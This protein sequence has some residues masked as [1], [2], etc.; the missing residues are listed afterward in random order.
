MGGD[1][2]ARQPPLSVRQP[3]PLVRGF[4]ATNNLVIAD[5]LPVTTIEVP[6]PSAEP[7]EIADWLGFYLEEEFSLAAPAA[8]LETKLKFH[9]TAA[10][11]ILR[12]GGQAQVFLSYL[13]E[14]AHEAVRNR[15][16]SI[17][18]LYPAAS[19][20]LRENLRL[21]ADSPVSVPNGASSNTTVSQVVVQ[22]GQDTRHLANQVLGT[23]S[24][25]PASGV[26]G[27]SISAAGHYAR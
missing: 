14:E 21:L 16:A 13:P 17:A 10:A 15:T 24:H 8:S 7:P 12:T 6:H 5:T 25:P 22:D 27:Q 3:H 19:A 26:D 4:A 18:K 23:T 11:A 2:W 20:A 1:A 9:Q